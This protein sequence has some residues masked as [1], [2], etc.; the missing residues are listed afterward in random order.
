M[1]M[2]YFSLSMRSASTA[3]FY[4]FE[5]A[6]DARNLVI[7]SLNSCVC[8]LCTEMFVHVSTEVTP[9]ST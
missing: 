7:L 2:L 4:R 6:E 5:L 9:G 1:K 3:T 8:G